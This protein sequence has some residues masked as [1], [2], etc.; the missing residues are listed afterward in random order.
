MRAP[1]LYTYFQSKSDLYDAMYAQGM[2][3]FAN[4]MER[5]PRGRDAR[6]AL[7][8]RVKTLARTALEDP[9]RY[10]LLFHRPIPG[11]VPSQESLA[12]GLTSLAET[13]RIAEAA[14]LKGERPFDLFLATTRGLVAMQLAN[15]PG[16]DRWVRLIDEA[17]D[18]LLTHYAG[19]G[20]K[21][22]TPRTKAR[23]RKRKE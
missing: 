21:K 18:I 15:Q 23:A 11:F 19:P 12:I 16:G 10:E 4:A 13:R 1:S 3:H 7:R 9:V 5:T 6:T 14:G 22:P 20:A 17:V 8:N 2:Q